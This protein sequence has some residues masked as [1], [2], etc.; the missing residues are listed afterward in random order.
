MIDSTPVDPAKSGAPCRF[1]NYGRHDASAS[2]RR[3]PDK[4]PGEKGSRHGGRAVYYDATSKFY[5]L[6]LQPLLAT[7]LLY[8]S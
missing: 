3:I 6:E 8:F 2:S 1:R 4:V 7:S 5:A